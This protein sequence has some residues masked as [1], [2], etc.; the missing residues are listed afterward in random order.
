MASQDDPVARHE[1]QSPWRQVGDGF[2]PEPCPWPGGQFVPDRIAGTHLGPAGW[3][4]TPVE[5]T[6]VDLPQIVLLGLSFFGDPFKLSAGWTEE[7]EIGRLWSRYTAFLTEHSQRIRHVTD[8]RVAYEV[9]VYSKDTQRTGEFEVF[10][11]T[12]VDRLEEVP[13]EL[14]AKILPPATYA[15]FALEGE[16]I[17]SDWALTILTEWMPQSGYASDYQY[18]I[19]RYDERFK[20]LDRL[21]ESKLDVLIPVIRDPT[22]E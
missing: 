18:S 4:R 14:S 17:A 16:Q 13:L 1:R 8:E 9:Q 19:Q 7:N 21:E 10:V 12:S 20:G 2:G 15:V 11:G 5:P 3:R 6:I 22:Q